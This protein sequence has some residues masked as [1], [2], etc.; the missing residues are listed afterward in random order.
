[1]ECVVM[2]FEISAKLR[3]RIRSTAALPTFT[4]QSFLALSFFSE[5][6]T[7][8]KYTHFFLSIYLL[9]ENIIKAFYHLN[10]FYWIFDHDGLFFFLFTKIESV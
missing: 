9:L 8:F 6:L 7:C 1:M 5:Y 10:V 2:W 3:R 4:R